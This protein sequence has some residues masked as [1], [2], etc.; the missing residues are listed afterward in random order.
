MTDK[1]ATEVMMEHDERERRIIAK[2]QRKQLADAIH[3][4]A[5][6]VEA[7]QFA[8]LNIQQLIALPLNRGDAIVEVRLPR[9]AFPGYSEQ[10]AQAMAEI[11]KDIQAAEDNEPPATVK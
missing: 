8:A 2:H 3:Q 10:R 9:E 11:I 5:E 4:I 1:T 7:G 6:R